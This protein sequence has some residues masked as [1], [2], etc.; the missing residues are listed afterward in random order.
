MRRSTFPMI[1]AGVLAAQ[2]C[3]DHEEVEARVSHHSGFFLVRRASDA[4]LPSSGASCGGFVA[5]SINDASTQCPDGRWAPSCEVS[6]I[7]LSALGLPAAQASALLASV[8]PSLSAPDLVLR[9]HLA[10]VDGHAELVALE[11]W[12][13]PSIA[14][15]RGAFHIVSTEDSSCTYLPC[16]SVMDHRANAALEP[17]P[18]AGVDLDGL[19]S[20]DPI[21]RDRC[22]SEAASD[23]GLLV[24]GTQSYGPH[25]RVL[26]AEQVFTR[27]RP[28]VPQGLCADALRG[29]LEEASARLVYPSVTDAPIRAL[30][31]DAVAHMPSAADFPHTIGM[32]T[33]AT[34]RTEPFEVFM[35]PLTTGGASTPSEQLRAARFR[36]LERVL[37]THLTDLTVYRVGTVD[38]RVYVVGLTACGEL[39]GVET[40]ALEQ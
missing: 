32:V 10:T 23:T 9:G 36:S 27:V 15:V 5:S 12:R 33:Q 17:E 21:A 18:I 11:A 29:A 6:A 19:T 24:A 7:D 38:V 14:P 31:P 40:T 35:Q 28:S 37:R 2:G 3:A 34:V 13:A 22:L 30:A 8:S 16:A 1:A 26:R 20:L 39:A 25:G 4:C